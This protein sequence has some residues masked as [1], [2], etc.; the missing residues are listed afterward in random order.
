M[1]ILI[2]LGIIVYLIIGRT[3]AEVVESMSD[4]DYEIFQKILISLFFPIIL[5]WFLLSLSA[6]WL[7]FE[8][9]WQIRKYK[10]RK[11]QKHDRKD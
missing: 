6:A 7:S 10:L 5:I 8:I 4:G 1:G 9:E 2:A 11:K 3:T